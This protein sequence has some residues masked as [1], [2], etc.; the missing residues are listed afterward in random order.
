M[1]IMIIRTASG[2]RAGVAPSAR[3]APSNYR[4]LGVVSDKIASAK[5]NPLTNGKYYYYYYYYY[6]LTY[7]LLLCARRLVIIFMII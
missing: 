6:Y 7:L 5:R 2:T 3:T 4:S 1:I